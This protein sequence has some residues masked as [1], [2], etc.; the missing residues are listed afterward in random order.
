M[1]HR[2]GGR[3]TF[4]AGCGKNLKL[5]TQ[6]LN[7]ESIK[8]DK[9]RSIGLLISAPGEENKIHSSRHTSSPDPSPALWKRVKAP[10][11]VLKKEEKFYL[12]CDK[13]EEGDADKFTGCRISVINCGT[14]G[15]RTEGIYSSKSRAAAALRKIKK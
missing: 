9:N 11:R 1:L 7:F 15:L 8:G 5:K 14:L 13:R 10:L 4:F 12:C 6:S 2:Q 3:G